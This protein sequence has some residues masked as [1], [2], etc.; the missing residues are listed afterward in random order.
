[1]ASD[2]ERTLIAARYSS[3]ELSKLLH[4]LFLPDEDPLVVVD[5]DDHRTVAMTG[6]IASGSGGSGQTGTATNS[7]SR[8]PGS[9]SRTG[10]RR[11]RRS[12]RHS[13]PAGRRC[14]TRGRPRRRTAVTEPIPD[15]AELRPHDSGAARLE[16]VVLEE[17][18][19]LARKRLQLRL[20]VV[21]V[22][23][24]VIIAVAA[25]AGRRVW[26]GRRYIPALLAPPPPPPKPALPMPLPNQVAPEPAKPPP[27]KKASHKKGHGAAPATA[28][29]RP[30]AG[31]GD[32]PLPPSDT[33][34]APEPN[35]AARSAALTFEADVERRGRSSRSRPP[36]R[37]AGARSFSSTSGGARLDEVRIVELLAQVVA[38]LDQLGAVLLQLRLLGRRVDHPLERDHHL[39]VARHRHRR[40]ADDV[41]AR[42]AGARAPHPHL[43]GPGVLGDD[44]LVA[45]EDRLLVVVRPPPAAP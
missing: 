17:Q 32:E 45:L 34:D 22:V 14:S 5:A 15:A 29:S 16:R 24:A 26:A 8:T 40:L 25:V 2:L 43:A 21:A 31:T 19:R 11:A 42:G 39:D 4:G 6:T 28:P 13:T 3:R 27:K 37:P 36:A 35:A 12:D 1:M 10:D 23:A 7:G 18:G 41:L 30:D 33:H 20:K 9:G 44:P 38:V